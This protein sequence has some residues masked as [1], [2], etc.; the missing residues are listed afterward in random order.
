MKAK[1]I[2]IGVLKMNQFWILWYG[3]HR[4]ILLFYSIIQQIQEHE[5]DKSMETLQKKCLTM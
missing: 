5:I 3:S 4:T 2:C 1:C